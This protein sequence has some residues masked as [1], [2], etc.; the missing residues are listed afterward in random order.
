M[1]ATPGKTLKGKRMAGHMG[2]ERVT[3]LNLEV[4]IVDPEKNLLAVRGS[5][6]G[7]QGGIVMIRP[8]VKAKKR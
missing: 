3:S 7:A 2:D 5:I 6:P 8:S 1:R 4:V